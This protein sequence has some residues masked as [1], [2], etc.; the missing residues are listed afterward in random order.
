MKNFENFDYI[1]FLIRALY[2]FKQSSREWYDTFNIWLL[3]QKFVKLE[4]NHFVFIN[5]RTK[6]IVLVYVNDLLVIESKEFNE[7]EKF[8]SM[9]RKRFHMTNLSSCHHYLSMTMTRNRSKKTFH[10]F[11]KF[12]VQKI[13]QRFEM[14]DCKIAIIF[15]KI[16]TRLKFNIEHITISKV[17]HH[18]V[19]VSNSIYLSSQTRSNIAYVV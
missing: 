11:Q 4:S 18:Q 12:Y 15:M 13:L 10:L 3:S 9:L 16:D 2:D 19:I 1:W 17:K 14:N 8:K 6:F 5:K 7:I